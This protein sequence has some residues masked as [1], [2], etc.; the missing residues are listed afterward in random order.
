MFASMCRDQG[1]DVRSPECNELRDLP[2]AASGEFVLRVIAG[3]L[4]GQ[5]NGG[6][7]RVRGPPRGRDEGVCQPACRMPFVGKT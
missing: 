6:L 5:P 4:C 3:L 1:T 2:L 7:L